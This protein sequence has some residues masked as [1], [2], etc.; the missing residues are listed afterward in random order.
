MH[1]GEELPLVEPS[2]CM[3]EALVTLSAKAM[4]AVII[5]NA[6]RDLLGIFTDGDLRRSL[7]KHNE[8]LH[9]RIADLMTRNPIAVRSDRMAVEA[10]RLMEDRPSQISVLPV[11]DAGGKVVGI[12]RIHDLLRAGL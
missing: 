2:M 10:L 6:E 8:L 3:R 12:V 11:L 4:G 5:M 1:R 7:E 9:M